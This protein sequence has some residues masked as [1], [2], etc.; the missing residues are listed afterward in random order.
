MSNIVKQHEPRLPAL[1]MDE[2]ELM[3]V[4]QSS[5][6]PGASPASIK[7]ALGYCKAA[8]LDPMQ[9]PVHI[10]PMW[11]S[12]A[13]SMRDVVMPGV[14]LYRTQAARSGECAGVSEPDFGP[15]TTETLGGQ[16]ITFPAWCR[17]TVKRRLPTGEVV[18]FTAKEFW[19]ENYAVKG[20]K[21]K[22][23]APNAMWTRRPYGQIAKCFD[24]ETEV[25]TTNGFERF[26]D[27][28]GRILQVTGDGLTPCDATP[29]VQAYSGEMIVADG[30]RMNF[31][32][33]PNHDMLTIQGKVE[34]GTLYEE[35][36][37]DASKWAIPRAPQ[38]TRSDAPVSDSA[39]RLAGYFMAD[40]SHTG[41]HQFRIAVSRQYKIDAL[42]ELMLHEHTSVK[43]DAG[44]VGYID[45]R[46][47]VTHS[48]KVSFSYPFSLIEWLVRP[49]KSI[50][51]DQLLSLSRRQ[52]RILVD[53]MVEF[54]G[55][56]PGSRT[57]RFHQ[58]NK[59]VIRAFEV[60]VVHAGMSISAR[61]PRQ[62]SDGVTVSVSEAEHFPVVRGVAKNRASLVKRKNVSGEVWCVTVPSSVIVVRRHGFSMLC[63]QCAEAQAL[64]KAFPEVGSQPTADEM[65]GKTLDM[66]PAEVV[67][68]PAAPPRFYAPDKFDHNLPKWAETI[69]QGRKSAKDYIDFAATRGEPFTE[70]QKAKLLSIKAAPP[71]DV[72][73][74]QPKNDA[75]PA[76]TYANLAG[77]LQ[78]A[79][80]LDELDEIATL[81][82]A[83]E[84]PQHRQELAAIYEDAQASFA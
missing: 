39:L 56:E 20:G 64:R 2:Q 54:D 29:F 17:V 35:A 7:M 3:Q 69:Q 19:K 22:S 70:E 76:V 71:A 60:A 18:E 50:D 1:Q 25:L 40:G 9:K 84:N 43:E 16:S 28:T 32:V 65:E 31:S 68:P 66:G 27:V 53:A 58:T 48:D 81:I 42:N 5:L 33:T 8:G 44:R 62:T 6:Y 4:L 41:Y 14:G 24:S 63:H 26:S 77:R 79:A 34:A 52:A 67:A 55:S 36:T 13:G 80:N 46:A 10:V 21:E 72:Q 82:G 74:V 59:N 45:N 15:D 73:D 57:R 37:A 61:A 83:V 11:D 23:I 75:A 49:D 51:V 47:I 12:K 78:N 30:T 38:S